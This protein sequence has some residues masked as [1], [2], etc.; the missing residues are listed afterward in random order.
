L[1]F[2]NKT[3]VVVRAI[4]ARLLARGVVYPAERQASGASRFGRMKLVISS[5][6]LK[7]FDSKRDINE[8]DCPSRHCDLRSIRS[9]GDE[10]LIQ[11]CFESDSPLNRFGVI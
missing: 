7:P 8:S 4:A 10:S 9:R 5:H 3:V 1:D 11:L 2:G 6:H